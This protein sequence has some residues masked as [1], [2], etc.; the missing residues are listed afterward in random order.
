MKNRILRVLLYTLFFLSGFSAINAQ[1]F[2]NRGKDFWLGYGYHQAMSDPAN[3]QNMVLYFTSG[4]TASVKVEIP[5]LG[6]IRTYKVM[7]NSIVESAPLPKGGSQD[8]R[9][10]S[11]GVFNTGIHITS[12][13]PIVAYAHIYSANTSAASLLFPVNTLGNDYYSLNFTQ[14]SS[15]K[16]AHSWAFVVATEDSTMVEVTPS[17]NSLTYSAG[18]AFYV[19]L[20]KGQIYNLFGSITGSN[21]ADLTGTRIRS[22]NTG[23]FTRKKIA[24]FSGS[25][26]TSI[27][28]DNRGMSGDVLFQQSPPRSA[29][30]RKYLTVP[31]AKLTNNYFRILVSNPST[32]VTIDGQKAS[33]LIN[34]LYYEITANTPKSI[35]SDK[36]VMVAQYI[37]TT[38][39]CDNSFYNNGDPEMIYLSPVEQTIE[40]V[41]LNSTNHFNITSH[42]INVVIKSS[43]VNRFQLDGINPVSSF[44]TH[45][46]DPAYSYASFAVAGG[47]HTLIA[48]SGFNAIAYGYGFNESYGYNAGTNIRNLSEILALQNPYAEVNEPITCKNTPFQFSVYLPYKTPSIVWDFGN[49]AHL[50]P[51]NTVIKNNVEP[52]STITRYGQKLY[53]YKL[54]S[55][56]KFNETGTYP[57]KIITKSPSED[58]SYMEQEINYDIQ[59]TALPIANF[60]FSGSGCVKDT[61]L[62]YDSSTGGDRAL[63]KWQWQFND[64]TIDENQNPKKSFT[65]PGTNPVKLT[66]IN[67]IGCFAD[68][69]HPVTQAPLPFAKFGFPGSNCG[70]SNITFA[71][72]SSIIE[73][74]IA[75]WNWNF[76]NGD[77]LTNT[78]NQAVTKTL[79]PGT[80]DVTLQTESNIGCKSLA[81]TKQLTIEA[82]PKVSFSSLPGMCLNDKAR[83]VTEARETTGIAGTFSFSGK[84]ISPLGLFDPAKAGAGQFAIG[85]VYTSI[86]G[87][88][89]SSTQTITVSE[90]PIIKLK[91]ELVVYKGETVTLEP[92]VSNDG[93]KYNWTPDTYLDN[94]TSKSVRSTPQ[95]SISY[96]LTATG[97]AG[98]TAEGSVLISLLKEPN[99]LTVTNPYAEVK[100]PVTCKNNPFQFSLYLPYKPTSLAWDFQNNPNLSPAKKVTRNN[101]QPDSTMTRDG[102]KVYLYKLPIV[103]QFKETGTYPVKIIASKPLADGSNEEHEINYDVEVTAPPVANFTFRSTGCVKDTAVFYDA[104]IANDKAVVKW[105]WQ[106]NDGTSDE[107][108]N[109][110]KSFDKA[111][112]YPVKLTA[113]N[114]IGCFA[115]TTI[116]VVQAPL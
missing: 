47:P 101:I 105:Q 52:D 98:C 102:Q 33:N 86:A 116:Q 27:S 40:Q 112:T 31:T 11:E 67:D 81:F 48:D 3:V 84:G 106:F 28:C 36:P 95:E 77:T 96:T 75:K 23:T 74:K 72:S 18:Q 110:R 66:A 4:Q 9:L 20:N 53:L 49:N 51:A 46:Y 19:T 37:T 91:P 82:S 93:Y 115:D 83:M 2:S 38:N 111:G 35:V 15:N 14:A 10:L 12:D 59:V 24:V 45:P 5:A 65:D 78:T 109:P 32:I 13:T 89:D 103:Y 41:T 25:G 1:D 16:K 108:K 80:Y 69:T 43:F 94:A 55:F 71:E 22:V 62:F 90:N 92:S 97:N 7:A 34:G 26:H 114:D 68:T 100:A 58:G 79:S 17:V 104:S 57:V 73:G 61:A 88:K 29:W 63:V 42:Y 107:H 50:F 60:S 21:G 56:Y 87:C 39:A 99:M 76:G 113:V 44:K 64:G 70:D 85:Y 8:A 54:Q 6:W 30:G